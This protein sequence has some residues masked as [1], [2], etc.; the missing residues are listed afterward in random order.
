MIYFLQMNNY[1]YQQN[2]DSKVTT[3]GMT[4]SARAGYGGFMIN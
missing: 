4:D 3:P 1:C 2:L